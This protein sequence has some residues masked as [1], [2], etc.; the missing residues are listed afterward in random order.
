LGKEKAQKCRA[1]QVIFEGGF[2]M[3][4][5]S[6]MEIRSATFLKIVFSLKM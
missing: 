4:W 5:I 1:K 2:S 3:M 6:T